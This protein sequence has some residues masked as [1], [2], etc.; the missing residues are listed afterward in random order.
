MPNGGHICCLY[1]VY[2]RATHKGNNDYICD[3]FG[4]DTGSGVLCRSFRLP[5]QSHRDARKQW[6]M[7]KALEPGVVY[8]IN[9][10]VYQSGNPKAMYRMV[11]IL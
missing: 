5:K 4:V 6:P 3:I 2:N 1:C 8:T 7:L 11:E 10:D 9:N